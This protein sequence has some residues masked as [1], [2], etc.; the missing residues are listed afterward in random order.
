M[1]R[2]FQFPLSDQ[3]DLAVLLRRARMR[4]GEAGIALE[5]DTTGGRFEGLADGTFRVTNGTLHVQVDRKP[6]F[7]PWALIESQLRQAF[8]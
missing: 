6:V 1:A 8:T 7:I 3:V 2:S 4:A 5:G